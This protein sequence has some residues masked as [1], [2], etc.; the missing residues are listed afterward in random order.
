MADHA[1]VAEKDAER[2]QEMRLAWLR[3]Y[4]ALP[5]DRDVPVTRFTTKHDDAAQVIG[6]NKVAFIFHML[7]G[8]L[9]EATFAAALRLFWQR[10]RFG[11]AGWT[12]VRRAFEAG[13][14]RDLGWFFEQWVARSGAPRVRLA[15]AG[16]ERLTDRDGYRLR[17]TVGQDQPT[18]RLTIPVV[19]E[20]P[21]GRRRHRIVL[22]G[23]ETTVT[24]DV[25][26]RPLGLHIDPEHDLF[27]RLLPGEAPPILRDVTLASNVVTVVAAADQAMRRVAL[28]LAERLLDTP[29]RLNPAA[30]TALKAA[31]VLII[32]ATREVE[33]L[34][35]RHGLAGVPDN[36]ANRGTSRVWTAYRPNDHPLLVVAA[37]DIQALQALLRPLPHYGAKSYLVCDGRRAVE[38][39]TWPATSSPLSHRFD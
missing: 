1:L 4:A 7:K 28:Q 21:A 12:D 8:E 33:K 10:H 25:D 24:L 16:V 15:R 38:K 29:V 14:G 37:D 11:V 35:A 19:I 2:G 39:G 20:T 13:S 17:F 9:G 22:E 36:L 31:P 32:G 34:L 26:A 5:A 23:A 30:S 3:D 6:Y 27:R 18:Y